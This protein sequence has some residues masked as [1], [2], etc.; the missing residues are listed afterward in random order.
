MVKTYS[1]AHWLKLPLTKN[2]YMTENR[3]VYPISRTMCLKNPQTEDNVQL[4]NIFIKTNESLLRKWLTTADRVI[5]VAITLSHHSGSPGFLSRTADWIFWLMSQLFY[6]IFPR[7]RRDETS[8]LRHYGFLP[9]F[10]WLFTHKSSYFMLFFFYSLSEL[11]R[12]S[13]STAQ[14]ELKRRL[15]RKQSRSQGSN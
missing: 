14:A 5:L 13:F 15:P 1:R 9:H 6:I 2:S 7:K 3:F 11:E 8:R 4:G 10:Y 12:A